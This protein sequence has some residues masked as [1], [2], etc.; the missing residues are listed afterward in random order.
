M[1]KL[2]FSL[3]LSCRECAAGYIKKYIDQFIIL[4][5]CNKMQ[6]VDKALHKTGVTVGT[7]RLNQPQ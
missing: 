2:L 6:F 3:P 5:L 1:L 4:I 7:I